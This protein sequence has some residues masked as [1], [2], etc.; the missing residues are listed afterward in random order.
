MIISDE[1]KRRFGDR[2]AIEYA[3]VSDANTRARYETLV[4][5]IHEQSLIYPVTFVD[6]RPVYDGAVSYPA[7]LRAVEGALGSAA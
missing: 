5:L 4:T 2:A 7:V 1:M 3:D 6:G